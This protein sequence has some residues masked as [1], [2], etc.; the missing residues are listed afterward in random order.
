MEQS[1][2]LLSGGQRQALTLMM[3]TINPPRLLLL[4][5]HTAALDPGTEEKVLRLTGEIV[6]GRRLTCLMITHN[7]RSAL[8]LGSR[9]IMMD[10]GRIILDVKGEERRGLTVESL[11]EKFRTAS[12]RALDNDR[13]LLN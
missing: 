5:E 12:G 7:M 11:T 8:Q 4:D 9:T 1:V 6:A 13:M 10:R 3:A 2:G